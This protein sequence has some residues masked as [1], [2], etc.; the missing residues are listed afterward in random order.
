MENATP[1]SAPPYPAGTGTGG[2]FRKPPVS[3]KRPST[4]YDRPPSTTANKQSH[5]SE[6]GGWISKL[7]VNPA[8]RLIVNGAT[9]ILPSFFSKSEPSFDEEYEDDSSSDRGE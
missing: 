3:R 5:E 1:S 2:K 6:D 9:R 8:R 7:V 4:P